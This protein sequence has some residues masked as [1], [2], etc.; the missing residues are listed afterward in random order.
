MRGDG[1]WPFQLHVRKYFC[2]SV[3]CASKIFTERLPAFVEPWARLTVR[4]RQALEAVGI[5]TCGEVGTRLAERLALPTSP[6]TLLRRI[7]ALPTNQAG[8]V[9]QLGIDDFALRRGRNYGTVLV[10]LVHHRVIDLLPDRKTETAK[11]WMQSHPEIHLVTRDRGGDY[12]S[13]AS[14]STLSR[15]CVSSAFT[16]KDREPPTTYS[17]EGDHLVGDINT[18]TDLLVWYMIELRHSCLVVDRIIAL[19]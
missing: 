10:D 14:L 11:V 19:P 16:R 18:S 2:D 8:L 17:Q 13:A 12:A 7:M 3:D 5:A 15:H 1:L 6:T 9:K 4:L